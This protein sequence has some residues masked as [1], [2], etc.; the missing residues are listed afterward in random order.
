MKYNTNSVLDE[1]PSK[2]N[3]T[4]AEHDEYALKSVLEKRSIIRVIEAFGIA[5]KR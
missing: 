4:Q 3:P 5:T 2:D 1:R